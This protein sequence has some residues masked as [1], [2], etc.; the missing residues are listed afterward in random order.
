MN[1]AEQVGLAAHALARAGRALARS[2]PWWPYALL[3]LIQVVIVAL[4]WGFAHPAV[5]WFAAPALEAFAGPDAVHYPA[6]LVALPSVA[7]IADLGLTV[8][9]GPV[10]VGA[11][12]L[13]FAAVYGAAPLG[14]RQAIGRAFRRSPALVLGVLP[15]HLIS[16]GVSIGLPALVAEVGLGPLVHRLSLVGSMLVVI[17]MQALALYV[18]GLVMLEGRGLLGAWRALPRTWGRGGVTALILCLA[19]LVPPAPIGWLLRQA[20]R[21]AERG[22]PELIGAMSLAQIAITLLAWFLLAGAATLAFLGAV[23]EREEGRA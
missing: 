18:P 12:T 7:G 5:S 4:V 23:A 1:V 10:V 19:L 6:N 16:F 8:L 3:G 9:L 15:A 14:A 21:I 13:L 20:P 22:T 11:A 17:V 2:R